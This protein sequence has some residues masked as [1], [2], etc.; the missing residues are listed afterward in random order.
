MQVE[1]IWGVGSHVWIHTATQLVR[2]DGSALTTFG[3]W[4]CSSVGS[5]DRISNVWGTNEND[6]FISVAGAEIQP[7]CGAAFVV[8]YDGELFHRF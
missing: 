4:T 3:N 5:V 6:V 2:W 7:P 1:R 8:H